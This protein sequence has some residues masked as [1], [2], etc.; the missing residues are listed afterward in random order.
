[1]EQVK[2]LG[3]DLRAGEPAPVDG[4]EQDGPDNTDDHRWVSIDQVVVVLGQ[5]CGPGYDGFSGADAAL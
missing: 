4:R 3:V 2:D 5:E 1:M